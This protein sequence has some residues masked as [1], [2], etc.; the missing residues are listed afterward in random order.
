M[1]HESY[2]FVDKTDDTSQLAR[3]RC[4]RVRTIEC[5]A[6]MSGGVYVSTTLHHSKHSQIPSEFGNPSA[7]SK[8]HPMERARLPLYAHH[9]GR[10]FLSQPWKSWKEGW[11][12]CCSAAH[13]GPET[14]KEFNLSRL[15]MVDPTLEL[16]LSRLDSLSD[17]V[18]KLQQ[19]IHAVEDVHLHGMCCHFI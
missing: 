11:R 16:H 14:S 15:Q 4:A 5:S 6:T 13:F 9:G 17:T 1:Q 18:T 19:E 7:S 3:I 8:P 12:Q 10:D 2:R